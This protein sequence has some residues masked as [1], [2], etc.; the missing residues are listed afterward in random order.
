MNFAQALTIAK[1][2][3]K[4][5]ELISSLIASKY[6]TTLSAVRLFDNATFQQKQPKG[7]SLIKRPNKKLGFVYYVRYY[8]DGKM[9]PTKWNTRTNV[10]EEA[11]RFAVQNRV[12][13]V[14][15]YL[16]SRD[17]K[18][19]TL[20]EG[21][22]NSTSSE[23]LVSGNEKI[24][25]RSRKDY[26][27]AILNCFIPFLKKKNIK[28]FSEITPHVLNVFQDQLLAG[29][30]KPQTVN[31]YYKAAKKIFKYLVR[32]GMIK[33]DPT[34]NVKNLPVH[35]SDLEVRGCHNLECLQG[36]FDK[37]WKNEVSYLL[38][39][40][41]YSTGMRNT[42]I[43]QLTMGDIITTGGC[44][45]I[46]IK[47]S[48]TESGIRKVPLHNFV[49][50]KLAL[51]ASRKKTTGQVFADQNIRVFAKANEE[52]G[53]RLKMSKEDL[54]KENITFYSG[55]HFWKTLMNSEGLGED[56][57]EIFMGHKV[58]ANVAKLYNHRDKQGNKRLIKK[59][60]QV[61]NILDKFI[62][63]SKGVG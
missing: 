1:Q 8:H 51:Y 11:E 60:K 37:K 2:Q 45:F 13:L 40:L 30:V 52:L 55:R 6:P 23:Y 20:L 27:R 28:H 49:Y 18:M 42:E 41:I 43:T 24:L 46:D 22:Y 5:F 19:Y 21:F 32:N 12:R 54:E 53:R 25:E 3:H 29:G 47:K 61:F 17:V 36:V 26:Q 56:I 9:L 63:N 57:E 31:N 15:L 4:P 58:S 35:Q 50:Q 16:R 59:T 62:F 44:R 48:K 10:L 34:K 38:C 14:E 33:E 7:Y 39:L